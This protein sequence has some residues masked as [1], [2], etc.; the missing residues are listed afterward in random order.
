MGAIID[1]L[2]EARGQADREA[3]DSQA[4]MSDQIGLSSEAHVLRLAIADA[5][6]LIS[7]YAAQ[8][9]H[10]RRLQHI[11]TKLYDALRRLEQR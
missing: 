7:E 4:V 9:E 5:A 11:H 8:A 1:A 6:R 3:K 10:H 2:T